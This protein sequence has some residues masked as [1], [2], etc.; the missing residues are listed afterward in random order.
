MGRELV[1]FLYLTNSKAFTGHH[2]PALL[3]R[4]RRSLHS[5]SDSALGRV[6]LSEKEDGEDMTAVW[7]VAQGAVLREACCLLIVQ[8]LFMWLTRLPCEPVWN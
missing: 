5:L 8:G 2:R 7:S 6:G 3:I 1:Y 4:R